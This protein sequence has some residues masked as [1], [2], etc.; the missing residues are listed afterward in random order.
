MRPTELYNNPKLGF[1]NIC[2]ILYFWAKSMYT[3]KGVADHVHCAAKFVLAQIINRS[4][5]TKTKLSRFLS[6]FRDSRF[7]KSN[8]NFLK[9]YLKILAQEISLDWS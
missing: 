5:I 4:N 7:S 1:R 6:I 3:L 8:K 2:A 9:V